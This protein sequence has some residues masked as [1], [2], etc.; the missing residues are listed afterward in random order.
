MAPMSAG[1]RQRSDLAVSVVVPS[2]GRLLRLRWLLNALEEQ[3]LGRD[4]FEV[5]VVHDYDD[6]Q[7]AA[8]I[9]RHPLAQ[10]G[11]VRSVRIDPARARASRQRNIGWRAARAPA[12]AF[13]DDDCR[14]HPEWL[15]RLVH[16]AARAPDAIVQGTVVGDPLEA[17]V[18]ARPLVRTLWVTPPDPRA[19]TANILYPK[20]LLERVDGFD[21]SLVVGEDMEL[22]LRCRRA[23]APL[24]AAPGALV[25]HA[26]EAFSLRG[27][28]RVNRKWQDLPLMLKAQP[29]LRR[30]KP[31]G[32]FWT[33]RH[34]RAWLA[35]AGVLAGTARDDA[36][37]L[38][39]PYLALDVV[40][41]RGFRP[42]LL[43]TA[44]SEAPR[45]IA[46]DLVELV[47]FARGSVRH[48]SVLL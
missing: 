45:V 39:L 44:L 19:Q 2:H 32:V 43:V 42:K 37:L 20:T 10:A 46:G 30:Y 23:G 5:V 9:E 41:R 6:A 35:G 4:R 21:E 17:D 1:E 7:T 24:A 40:P 26:V 36:L 34:L 28:S 11:V 31:L 14:P 18:F 8:M 47:W 38:A 33:W 27:W 12:V 3:T 29:S 13:V 22:C 15:E 25:F 16:A 48:R